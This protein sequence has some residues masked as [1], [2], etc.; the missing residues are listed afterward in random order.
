MT[1]KDSKNKQSAWKFIQWAS[2]PEVQAEWYKKSSDLPASQKAWDDDALSG[3]DKLK[4]TMAPPALSTWAQVSSAA[5]RILE[6]MN[7]RQVTVDEGLKNLQSE[8]DSIGT[9]N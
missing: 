5:D 9:G 8:A 7:K 1:F 3:N 4:N 6:Q 2:K